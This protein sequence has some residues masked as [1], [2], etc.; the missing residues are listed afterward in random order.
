MPSPVPNPSREIEKLWTRTWDHAVD[1]AR[2][3]I[4]AAPWR[5]RRSRRRRRVEDRT[6]AAHDQASPVG[7]RAGPHGGR[8]VAVLG[9]D[10]RDEDREVADDLAHVRQLARERRT[11]HQTALAVVDPLVGDHAGDAHVQRLATA[12]ERLQVGAARV[13]G[14]AQGDHRA[15]ERE[16]RQDRVAAQVRVDRD[17]VRPVPGERLAR[18]VLGRRSDVAALGVEDQRH[19]GILLADVRAEPL[20]LGLGALRREE[21]DLRLERGRRGRRWRRRSPGRTP[22]SGR[23]WSRGRRGMP[24]RVGVETDA[25]HRSRCGPA[26]L[27]LVVEAHG[28]AVSPVS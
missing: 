3:S 10:S 20:E 8:R 28:P 11:D 12:V 17:G 2:A 25:H 26:A 9:T 16:V 23:R 15:A 27:Q 5:R 6:R 13:A 19:V 21:R 22:T 18:V 14:A 1:A 4:V 7:R 24:R